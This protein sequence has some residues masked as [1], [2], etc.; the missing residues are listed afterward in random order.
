MKQRIWY[1][2]EDLNGGFLEME[3]LQREDRKCQ[4]AL[5]QGT[6][7]ASRTYKTT[8]DLHF[9]KIR[10]FQG[11]KEHHAQFGGMHCVMDDRALV[12]MNHDHEAVRDS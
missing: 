2:E 5:Y 12:G 7:L 4:S 9:I 11:M 10:T 3:G 8:K 1:A 6:S